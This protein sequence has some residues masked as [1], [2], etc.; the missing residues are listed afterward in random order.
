MNWEAYRTAQVEAGEVCRE[1][2]A[3]IVFSKGKPSLCIPCNTLHTDKGEVMH[4]QRA[5]CP[6][7]THMFTIESGDSD[8]YG[9][10][11]HE[12]TCPKCEG[13]FTVQTAVS[14]SFTSPPLDAG[15]PQAGGG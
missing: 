15:S 4:S 6:H 11:E 1:C 10:G 5:R 12:V 8:I 13:E 7:C 2:G 9:E 14:Y 3:Y